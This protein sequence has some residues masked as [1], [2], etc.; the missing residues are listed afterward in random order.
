M[1][2]FHDLDDF[3]D[4]AVL[5]ELDREDDEVAGADVAE[6]MLKEL[7]EVNAQRRVMSKALR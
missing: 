6:A 4:P 2:P 1:D 5:D 7:A 3:F